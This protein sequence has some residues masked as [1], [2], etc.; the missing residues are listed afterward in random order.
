MSLSYF[1]KLRALSLELYLFIV[2]RIIAT[3]A[4]CKAFSIARAEYGVTL[5][6]STYL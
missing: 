3:K 4:Q 1:L 6:D 2:C 5:V